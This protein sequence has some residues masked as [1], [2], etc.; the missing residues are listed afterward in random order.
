MK[1]SSYRWGHAGSSPALARPWLLAR[2]PSHWRPLP[3]SVVGSGLS[4]LHGSGRR[5]EVSRT[6]SSNDASTSSAPLSFPTASNP[7]AEDDGDDT[8]AAVVSG[9]PNCSVGIVRISGPAAVPILKSIFVRTSRSGS[10]ALDGLGAAERNA[11]WEP[12]SHR[13]YHGH[14]VEAASVKAGGEDGGR[15]VAAKEVVVDE[16]LAIPMLGRRSYTAEDVVEFQTHGGSIC[17]RRVLDC[18]VALGARVAKPGEF[19]YRAFMNGRL[20]LTQAEAVASVINARTVEA[21]DAALAGLDGGL[22]DLVEGMR[23][24]CVGL[25]ARVDAHIDYE[26]EMEPLDRGEILEM[27][28]DLRR[29]AGEALGTARRGKFL[30][31]GLTVALIGAPNVGK[32]SLL[33][34]LSGAEKAIVT[35]I[36]G[37]TRD[38]VEAT[39]DMGGVATKLLD[40]AGIRED[41][42]D[43]VEELG[44]QRSSAAARAADAVVMVV[45]SQVGW[46]ERETQIVDSLLPPGSG[47]SELPP[48]VLVFNQVDAIEGSGLTPAEIISAGPTHVMERLE[49]PGGPEVPKVLTS[50]VTGEGI[51]D[52]RK[53]VTRIVGLKGEDGYSKSVWQLNTRQAACLQVCSDRLEELITA[54]EEGWPVDCCA[55]H[56]RG[57]LQAL[58]EL[59]GSDVTEDVLDSIFSQFCIGK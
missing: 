52:I 20:D 43:M 49:P 15:S 45:N 8:I 26:D 54:V 58:N 30:E 37:T 14:L 7:G 48:L 11:T 21:A 40:T 4:S 33:N 19:T 55:V 27:C 12:C 32:S 2:P 22:R 18:C 16:A 28:K 34:A 29:S 41:V 53:E 36:A 23:A 17:T 56:L 44:V 10:P 31:S 39:T 59:T 6:S 47:S 57:A 42:S 3:S 50:A 13:V 35:E 9:G 46:G 24:S 5:V 1:Q 38:I 51:P 25:L